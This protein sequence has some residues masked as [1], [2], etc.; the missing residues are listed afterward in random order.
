MKLYEIDQ[1]IQSC[2]AEEVDQ[3]TGE[4]ISIIIDPDRMEKLMMARNEKIEN[5]ACWVK[6]LKAENAAIECEEK[7]LYSRRKANE[8]RIKSLNEYLNFALCG[9][10]YK[11][12]KADVSFR[13]TPSVAIDDLNLIPAEY[14]RVKTIIDPDKIAIKNALAEKEIPGAHI[15]YKT[16]TIIR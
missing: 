9:Q 4:I 7:R 16:S 15:D 3:E 12:V 8:N 2:M 1:Q 13:S 5:I 14:L 11:G 6:N 10:K